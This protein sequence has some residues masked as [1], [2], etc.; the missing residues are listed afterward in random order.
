MS[1]QISLNVSIIM[2]I[3]HVQKRPI[4]LSLS[5]NDIYSCSCK[6][7]NIHIVKDVGVISFI[8]SIRCQTIYC[9]I[10][11][12]T[13]GEHSIV[14]FTFCCRVLLQIVS[15]MLAGGNC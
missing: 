9:V 3:G 13:V 11:N 6:N 14:K 5:Y 10:H 4:A 15:V 8:L 1:T 2:I 12:R 7:G